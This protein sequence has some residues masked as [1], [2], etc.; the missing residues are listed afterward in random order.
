M[1]IVRYQHAGR[2]A[3]GVLSEDAVY[4]LQGDL[5]DGPSRGERIAPLSDVRLLAPIEPKIIVCVGN[6][7]DELLKA[8]G[9]QRPEIPNVFLKAI[10][11]LVGPNADVIKPRENRFEFEG[12]LTLVISRT[13]QRVKASAWRDYVLG[14]TIGNDLSARDWQ[15]KDTQWWRAKSSD[16]FCPVGPWIETELDDP[17]NRRLR[18]LVNG[19]VKQDSSTSDMTFKL[20][21]VLEIVSSSITLQPGDIVLT[22]TPPGFTPLNDGDVVEVEIEGLGSLRNTVREAS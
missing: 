4:E 17:E 9:L 2:A 13:A 18:T 5:Y 3:Y 7:Y 20:G 16:T 19:E 11:A 6:N 22:G 10:N 21:E 8:K 12:E 15:Q 1:R 14:F